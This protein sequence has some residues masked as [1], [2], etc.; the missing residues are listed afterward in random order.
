MRDYVFISSAIKDGEFVRKLEIELEKRGIS[1][2]PDRYMRFGSDTSSF[3]NIVNGIT[4]CNAFLVVLSPEALKSHWLERE[5]HIALHEGKH[6]VPVI[7]HP[8]EIPAQ[9][10]GIQPLDFSSHDLDDE[11]R[12]T[13]LARALS[14]GERSHESSANSFPSP[15][16]Y[17]ESSTTSVTPQTESVF[18]GASAP[19][20]IRPGDEFTA[21]F[22]AYVESL[23]QA[24]YKLLV[25]LNPYAES[26]MGVQ[27]CLWRPGTHVKVKLNSRYL[28][29]ARPE[30]EFVWE[31]G[32]YTLLEFAIEVPADAP[33]NTIVLN[34]DVSVSDITVA[35]LHLDVRINQQPRSE[36]R[37]LVRVQPAQSAF[38][39]YASEDRS[40]VLDRVSAV[41]ISTGLDV[42]L[43]CLSLR[44]SEQ[45]KPQLKYEIGHRDLF[46][47]F[48]SNSAAHSPWVDWE[49]RTALEE[50][51]QTAM[52]I[53]PLE[54]GVKP[55]AEL[56]DL[57]FG[58]PF[59]LIREAKE[60]DSWWPKWVT[61]IL[62]FAKKLFPSARGN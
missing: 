23:R 31:G 26:H 21:R 8:C 40:R 25:K 15:P 3:A 20:T 5:L 14:A 38:A 19:Q 50:K 59:M 18:L 17:I 10:R 37:H 24:V 44:P 29:I 41:S 6:I 57:H 1:I 13:L 61:T 28:T 42:F 60:H 58:D 7:I 43:D 51:G 27:H 9:L 47:L 2:W 48:W 33:E 34:F 56:Q 36:A 46:L 16:E 30:Q 54:A 12:I 53:H 39:S 35:R 32:G 45:W 52:Q 55:P 49:W 62:S 11:N 4:K 22:V